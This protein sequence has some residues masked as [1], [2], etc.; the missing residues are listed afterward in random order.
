MAKP[1]AF[2]FDIDNT[3]YPSREFAELARK[4][5]ISAMIR[6]GLPASIKEVERELNKVIMEKGSNYPYHFDKV[7]DAFGV[8]NK[9]K[10]V[11]AAVAAYHDTKITI[12]PY[13]EV[14]RV[15]LWLRD[16]RIKLYVASEGIEV[17]QWDKLLRLQVAQYFEN[18]FVANPSKGGKD[19][20]F[21]RKIAKKI[22]VA[23]SE[24]LMVG[25]KEDK[26]IIPAKKASYRTIR[27]FRGPYA[28]K[29]RKTAA[30]ISSRDL[31][32]LF[33]IID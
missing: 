14:P 30:D 18:V 5:A 3:L 8:K 20:E 28:G 12:L 13:P 29:G 27:I 11:A 10:Y 25:D 1:R 16:K 19:A 23:P 15:L 31:N 7:L 33:K 32:I 24:C 21:Y 26:D 4:N 6:A 9:A 2:F 22:N 17:K